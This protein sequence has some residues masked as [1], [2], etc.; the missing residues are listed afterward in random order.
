M[1]RVMLVVLLIGLVALTGTSASRLGMEHFSLD[2]GLSDM[3]SDARGGLESWLLA[4][5]HHDDEEPI[6]LATKYVVAPGKE[7][8]FEDAWLQLEK[9]AS[10]EKSVRIYDL[11]K[12][13]T[14]NII[15]VSYAEFTNFRGAIE[16]IKTD[17]VAKFLKYLADKDI[18]FKIEPLAAPTDKE[19]RPPR[20]EREDEQFVHILAKFAVPPSEFEDFI[21]AWESTLKGVEGE[22]GNRIYSLRKS[23]IDNVSFT[24][25]GT[26]DSYKAYQEHL[27]SKYARGLL[28]HL[29]DRGIVVFVS[30]LKKIGH[31]PE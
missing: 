12:T 22:K 11:K 31:Q 1:T 24:L 15:Y 28:R 21:G 25:Y 16:H 13:L 5:S 30:P 27:E 2:S 20:S 9:S 4:R 26:W 18:V 10:K 3:M 29:S 23:K 6:Y 8:D 7:D 14:D 19:I 17:Y